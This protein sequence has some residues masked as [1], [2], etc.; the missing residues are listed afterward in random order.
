MSER[1]GKNLNKLY[2]HLKERDNSVSIL[3]AYKMRRTK[4]KKQIK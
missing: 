1:E 2:S 3:F 4:M